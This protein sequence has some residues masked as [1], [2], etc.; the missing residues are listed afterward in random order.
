M[1][2]I[3]EIHTAVRN[4]LE[5]M[6]K[7]NK[8]YQELIVRV[9]AAMAAWTKHS[10]SL[11]SIERQI[12]YGK[13]KAES[14]FGSECFMPFWNNPKS[15]F[16]VFLSEEQIAAAL[17][18]FGY[19]DSFKGCCDFKS[20]YF[21]KKDNQVMTIPSVAIYISNLVAWLAKAE[22]VISA[23]S[24]TEKVTLT[25]EEIELI[26]ELT[27]DHHYEYSDDRR[28]ANA[29]RAAHTKAKEHVKAVCAVKPHLR[30]VV[31]LYS[32]SICDGTRYFD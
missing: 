20:K 29:G 22:P 4:V 19:L 14:G 7:S 31:E 13:F 2:N 9:D 6:V 26:K 28:V 23:L 25:D 21:G 15:M 1:S 8:D 3:Y 12:F 11:S 5:G 32:R 27:F 24:N 18:H 10:E 17:K 30:Q 16:N